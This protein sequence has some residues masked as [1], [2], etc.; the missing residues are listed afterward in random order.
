MVIFLGKEV[1]QSELDIIDRLEHEELYVDAIDDAIH[2]IQILRGRVAELEAAQQN[3][4][5]TAATPRKTGAKSKGK[6][7][8]KSRRA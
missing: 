4:Q 3:V 7:A 2:E 6:V 5:A 1:N 8:R